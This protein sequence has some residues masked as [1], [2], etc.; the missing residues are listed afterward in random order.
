[1]LNIHMV[2][3]AVL[4]ALFSEFLVNA[5]A[6]FG[7]FDGIPADTSARRGPLPAVTFR[8]DDDE[9]GAQGSSRESK[10]VDINDEDLT[11]S[12]E[13][14]FPMCPSLEEMSFCNSIRAKIDEDG[15]PPIR[16][17][18]SIAREDAEMSEEQINV[19]KD[20]PSR[21]NDVGI[22]NSNE[23]VKNFD[24]HLSGPVSQLTA[25]ELGS[26]FDDSHVEEDDEGLDP[27]LG[28][29]PYP[30][31]SF[32]VPTDDVPVIQEPWQWLSPGSDSKAP[33]LLNDEF[34]S[35]EDDSDERESDENDVA[36]FGDLSRKR[37]KKKTYYRPYKGSKSKYYSKKKKTYS[38]PA[39]PPPSS[40]S[41]VKWES[42][43]YPPSSIANS[44]DAQPW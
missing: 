3:L 31:D 21:A 42:V 43:P 39:P 10:S 19:F 4:L 5:R 2:R 35:S 26:R 28:H 36:V 30:G 44:P 6:Q 27:P 14:E 24:D 8:D 40:K 41:G 20:V 1:M 22:V 13:H 29:Q 33:Q 37:S 12:N 11:E 16:Y 32:D 23:Y 17:P 9:N 25:E 34:A 18:S 38:K 15:C 7:L